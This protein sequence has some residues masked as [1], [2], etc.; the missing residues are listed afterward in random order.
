MY[1]KNFRQDTS[2]P[3][4]SGRHPRVKKPDVNYE[5]VAV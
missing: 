5:P 1:K 2:G 4:F 3:G